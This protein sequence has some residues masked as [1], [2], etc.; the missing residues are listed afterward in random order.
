ML[1]FTLIRKN[2]LRDLHTAGSS[3]Y[4]RIYIYIN[5]YTYIQI[6]ITVRTY[7]HTYIHIHKLLLHIHMRL[8]ITY[9]NRFCQNTWSAGSSQR[10]PSI[11][12]RAIR[13]MTIWT[14]YTKQRERKGGKNC[15]TVR[16]KGIRDENTKCLPVQFQGAFSASRYN[17]KI[18]LQTRWVRASTVF[19]WL[20]TGSNRGHLEH[21]NT[22]SRSV[23]GTALLYQLRSSLEG[24]GSIDFLVIV[25]HQIQR[26][27]TYM[28]YPPTVTEIQLRHFLSLWVPN[29]YLCKPQWCILH[30]KNYFSFRSSLIPSS[31]VHPIQDSWCIILQFLHRSGFHYH[32]GYMSFL[33][34]FVFSFSLYR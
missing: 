19:D 11:R 1:H 3:L 18:I 9:A 30:P 14:K 2:H 6:F 5:M 24:V 25:N 31:L 22:R 32:N 28:L 4:K 15:M 26:H 7:I 12:N 33:R 21:E 29:N 10:Q 34:T 27:A 8:L 23:H 17:T 13:R 20:M 16:R